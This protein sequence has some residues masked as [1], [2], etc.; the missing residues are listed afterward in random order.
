M[1][2]GLQSLLLSL[3]NLC[4]TGLLPISLRDY[5][6]GSYRQFNSSMLTPLSVYPATWQGAMAALNYRN[7]QPNLAD[8]NA[9]IKHSLPSASVFLL[10]ASVVLQKCG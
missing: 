10:A 2:P 8:E 9:L 3:I 7:W 4:Y 6:Q 5:R 1:H